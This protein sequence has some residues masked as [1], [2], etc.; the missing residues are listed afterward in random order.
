ML[1]AENRQLR[2]ELTAFRLEVA[3]LSE[4]LCRHVAQQSAQ[5]SATVATTKSHDNNSPR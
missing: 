2:V 1:E 5:Q 4:L 3:R